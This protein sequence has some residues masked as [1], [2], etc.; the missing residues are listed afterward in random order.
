MSGEQASDD[1]LSNEELHSATV[2]GLR[3][4]MLARPASELAVVASMLV[5]T[6]LVSPAEFGRY[7]VAAVALAF[8]IIP[9]GAI[10]A[11]F[12]QGRSIDRHHVRAAFGLSLIMSF[13]SA[14]LMLVVA[15][16]VIGPI[17]DERTATLVA[18]SAPT[19][20]VDH[21]L[22]GPDGADPAAPRVQASG[23]HQYHD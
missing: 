21:G 6:R 4:T 18:L 10:N 19:A 11:A 20:F 14:A 2:R 17:F 3:W 15:A 8:G 13:V 5:L 12:V 7:A 22:R 23:D 9:M 1:S 16:T